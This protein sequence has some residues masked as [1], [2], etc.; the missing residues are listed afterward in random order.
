MRVLLTVVGFKF[1]Q[2]LTTQS[3][4]NT[5]TQRMIPTHHPKTRTHSHRQSNLPNAWALCAW[6]RIP[7]HHTSASVGRSVDI[8]WWHGWRVCL[9]LMWPTALRFFA[10]RCDKKMHHFRSSVV[11]LDLKNL[12]VI[13][14]L[15]AHPPP[16][17]LN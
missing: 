7:R 15:D 12:N 1:K 2:S 13:T 9:L 14:T 10:S 16:V 3:P 5:N 4:T 6:V 17:L 8:G 11:E